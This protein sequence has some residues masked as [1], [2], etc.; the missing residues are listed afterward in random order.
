MPVH[1]SGSK[2]A[3]RSRFAA[4][5]TLLAALSLLVALPG[6]AGAATGDP[7]H[8]ARGTA[9]MGM[10]VIA[11]DG[12]GGLPTSR[13][14][15]TEGVDVSGHQNAVNWSALWSSGVKWAYVKASEG[16]YYTNEDFTQQYNGSYNV[17]M[18]RGSYHFATPD[19]TSGAVQANY[20]VDH[21]GGW[22][23]DG[24]TLPGVLDIE[25]N[26]YGA[27]C[28]GKTAAGMVSWIRDFVNTYKARTGRDAVIYT[29]TSWWQ[30]CTGNSASF[31]T[32]NPLWVARYN[33]TVG[34]LPAGWGFYTIWQYTSTGPTVGD[35]NHFN[36]A[37]DR[38]QALANG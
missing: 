24:R 27:Q 28:Y 30:S 4:A 15:Q 1:R 13:A 35:H 21:G 7:T 9:T 2:T 22:S 12:Q 29:A 19:T 14:V 23:K 11:H 3:R 37:L 31:G 36:G 32:T 16:T 33:T 5:G 18:I 8:P 10:G 25:W 17:G 20:F 26:P 38:V 6:A 34:T